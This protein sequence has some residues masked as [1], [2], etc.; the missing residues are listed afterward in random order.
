MSK[1][2]Q[3]RF[4]RV[5]K[6]LKLERFFIGDGPSK[7][8]VTLTSRSVYILPTREGM[9][10]VLVL[11]AMLLTAFNYRNSLLFM[12]TFLLT[13]LGFVA[14]LH[15]W[16]NL[17]GLTFQAG[18]ASPVFAGEMARFQVQLNN[19]GQR[20]RLNLQLR[21]DEHG[22]KIQ[23]IIADQPGNDTALLDLPCPATQRGLLNLGRFTI[24]TRFPLGLF[25]AWS[26]LDLNM[27]AVI[28]PR[29][30]KPAPL[31]PPETGRTRGNA[32]AGEGM[33]DFKSLREYIP[34]DS[35]QHIHW[36]A[37]A[38]GQGML[39]KEFAGEGAVERWLNWDN[40]ANLG[41]E[42]RLSQLCRWVLDADKAGER[43]GLRL[44]GIEIAPAQ[45]EKHL[46]HCLQSLALFRVEHQ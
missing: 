16:R 31:P 41:I 15:T 32:Q 4:I 10:F 22:K 3:Q 12:L 18:R 13:G 43:Y 36:K 23:T 34:Q 17:V 28:Y 25:R 42:A 39:T 35:P 1:I 7:K 27:H 8:P 38:R 6:A 33:D 29:P 45:G 44:P 14:M 30:G 9:I 21:P 37:S 24:S 11:L 40:L 20:A 19:A 2:G 5:L 46:Y 26:Y